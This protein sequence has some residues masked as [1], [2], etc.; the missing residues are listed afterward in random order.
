MTALRDIQFSFLH[1]IYSGEQTSAIYLDERVG[2]RARLSI[3]SN[4]TL[5]GLT[6]VLANAYPVLKKIVGDEFFKTIARHYL[7]AHP[8]SAGNRHT[9]GGA[10]STFLE[11]FKPVAALPYLSDIAALEWA[12]FQAGIADD[13][14]ATGFDDLA[15]ALSS[16]PAFALALHP[17]VHV[18]PQMFN[19]LDIWR[20]HQK[21]D[22]GIIQLSSEPHTIMIW[23]TQDDTV[24]IRKV[25]SAFAALLRSCQN[26]VAF[27]DAMMIARDGLEDV[28]EF[29]REFAEAMTLEV[30]TNKKGS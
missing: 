6:D 17:S 3:Y 7:R 4:N 30:F 18:V 10:L 14:V 20:E 26:G 5:F 24:L 1:D 22:V 12:H 16:D 13:A 19:A 9:F 15:A 2:S 28:L 29:Q 8:Q 27:G 11:N 23:R 25:T 21:E